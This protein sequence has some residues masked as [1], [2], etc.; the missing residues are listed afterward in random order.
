MFIVLFNIQF[1]T[2]HFYN[3]QLA[4]DVNTGGNWLHMMFTSQAEGMPLNTVNGNGSETVKWGISNGIGRDLI[5]GR[6]WR[7][8]SPTPFL[9]E[10]YGLY[11]PQYYKSN[12]C[13]T[14]K[15]EKY[16]ILFLFYFHNSNFKFF[17]NVIFILSCVKNL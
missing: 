8:A 3:N 13:Y 11:G 1:S 9:Y 17:H 16:F 4:T 12:K 10:D 15:Y 6:P 14:R 5:T 2:D 7:R